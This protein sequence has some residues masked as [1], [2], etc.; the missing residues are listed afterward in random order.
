[1]K[2]SIALLVGIFALGLSSVAG[3]TAKDIEATYDRRE[4]VYSVS[5]HLWMTPT[6]GADNQLCMMRLYPKLISPD[7]NYLD[8]RLD[9]D[10]VL[11]FTDHL[12]PVDTSGARK[13]SFGISDLGRG[14]V[15]THFNY[16]QVSFVF[17][18]TFKLDKVAE[19]QADAALMRRYASGPKV[20]EVYWANRKCIEPWLGA[21]GEPVWQRD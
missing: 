20:L 1:M 2:Y 16:D 12:V 9:L 14:V 4:N 13:D 8:A 5:E 6:Y 3:Q 10:E 21:R 15:W 11:E 18:S 17:I 7:T 19:R